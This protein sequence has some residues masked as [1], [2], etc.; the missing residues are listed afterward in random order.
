MP[1]KEET[2]SCLIVAITVE[3]QQYVHLYHVSTTLGA[4]MHGPEYV[5]R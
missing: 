2:S 3:P 5:H 1:L 4:H